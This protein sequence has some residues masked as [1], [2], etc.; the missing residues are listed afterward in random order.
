[1]KKELPFDGTK[2]YLGTKGKKVME[3]LGELGYLQVDS[4]VDCFHPFLIIHNRNKL[5]LLGRGSDCE[6]F[7]SNNNHVMADDILNHPK[8]KPAKKILVKVT[9]KDGKEHEILSDVNIRYQNYL[10]FYVLT[11]RGVEAHVQYNEQTIEMFGE[12]KAFE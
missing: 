2:V 6:F 9:D 12:A 11:A 7:Q 3:K 1:M 8:P 10:P 4:L 5:E